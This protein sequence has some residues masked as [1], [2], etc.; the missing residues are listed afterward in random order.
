VK[1]FFKILLWLLVWTL[2]A[3]ACVGGALFA[4]YPLESGLNILGGLFVAYLAF[5]L[6]RKA[7]IHYQAKK[8]VEALVNT[9]EPDKKESTLRILRSK[10]GL[11]LNFRAVLKMLNRS[12]LKV[13]G[14]PVYVLP[15]YLVI[16]HD[17]SGKTFTLDQANLPKPTIDG[18]V[19]LRNDDG[20]NWHLYNQ[21]IVLDTPGEF[22]AG[23]A[24]SRN[25]EW[26]K[27]LALLKKHR[28]REPINGVIVTLPMDALLEGNSQKLI[29]MGTQARKNLEQLIQ[30]LHVQVPIYV[31]VT[32]LDLL[33]G[34]TEWI[35]NLDQERFRDPL[36]MVNT[37]EQSPG[38]FVG[39]TVRAL[40]ERLK[41]LQLTALQQDGVSADLIRLPTRFEGLERHLATYAE[42]IFQENPYQK[43][44][45][46]RGMYFMGE[47]RGVDLRTDSE[48]RGLFSN[49][50][51][52][53][54]VPGERGM[55]TSLARIER[56]ET[57]RRVGKV[58]V[59][60][61]VSAGV[62]AALYHNFQG[63]YSLLQQT[64]D[65]NAGNFEEAVAFEQN[66]KTMFGYRNM[67]EQLAGNG[68]APWFG[69]DASQPR[70]IGQLQEIF[71]E[72]VRTRLVSR[73]DQVFSAVMTNALYAEKGASEE[74][75]VAFISTLVRRINI[76][77]AYMAGADQDS[78]ARMPM[79]YSDSDAELFG[80]RDVATVEKL[81]SLYLQSLFWTA[82]QGQLQQELRLMDEQLRSILVQ[83]KALAN[84]L[85]PWANGVMAA[86]Q[87]RVGD[88][89]T[90]GSGELK[91][92]TAITGAYTL[93]GKQLIDGFIDQIRATNRYNNILDEILPGFAAS[94]KKQYLKQW[95]AFATNFQD[96]SSKL[97]NRDEWLTVINNLSTGRNIFFNA[98]DLIYEQLEPYIDDEDLPD[99]AMM[100]AYYQDMRAFGPE[101]KTDDG[102]QGQ[103]L[104]KMAMQVVGKAGPV[105][106]AIAGAGKSG[107]KSKKK[108]DKAAGKSGPSA[109]EREMQLEQAGTLLGDY[110][111]ALT[112]F[113]YSAEVR[114]VSYSAMAGLYANPDRPDQGES[115]LARGYASL[116]KLQGLVGK[117]NR[118][119]KAFWN[120]YTGALTLMQQ[121][122]VAESA[123][124]VQQGWEN[125]FL[126][127]LQGVPE[128]K[129]PELA[130]GSSGLLWNVLQTDLAPFVREQ[131]GAGYVAR[132][133]LG[134]VYPLSSSFLTFAARSRDARQAKQDTYRVDIKGMPTSTNLDAKYQ[135]SQTRL[136][137]RCAD[138]TVELI[139]RNFP[140]T[141]NFSWSTSC[142]DVVLSIDIGRFSL[143]K[144]YEGP[145]GFPNFLKE[146]ARGMKRFTPSD[147]PANAEQL[148]ES[149][150]SFMEVEYRITGQNALMAS[151]DNRGL[152]IPDRIAA[153]WPVNEV[154]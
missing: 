7:V 99:W 83:S 103:V 38:V 56:V 46:F 141:R 89:W 22:L 19:S 73:A 95:E 50:F 113:V 34:V 5:L 124:E 45:L 61:L 128:Y 151:L 109:D 135:V 105:G 134:S 137:L 150:V 143:E 17:Q 100:L 142:S 16:G 120:L 59:W 65:Q 68:W 1:T 40:A 42:S 33:P 108:L 4:G 144:R 94:Y 132:R 30:V 154:Q 51:F 75:I 153:C 110:R 74:Q 107:M 18:D 52:T 23:V 36:G 138:Q 80:I 24:G 140:I 66:I 77:D 78:L 148:R 87:V 57:G 55:L 15:W 92:D 60:Y 35:A 121:F 53:G 131:L 112:D 43:T 130:F 81:N 147:F 114:S 44:P 64:A 58:A 21:A 104:T 54:I 31:I 63:N 11:D 72:R 26:L 122:M 48:G 133:A 85:I 88:F 27:L 139:N 6:I 93:A 32:K 25:A 127:N 101:E 82:G 67:V 102:K 71:A 13:H 152:V 37:D 41:Q 145:L 10:T 79:P 20:I 70:F 49:R 106:K 115:S 129:L 14:D 29:E 28:S 69:F 111:Q 98:M 119:N 76:L 3:A 125:K 126:A 118:D 146:F 86:E 117:E 136:E 2:I 149:G 91:K 9:A 90:A 123:C 116:K 96:G 12:Y 39:N 62:M 47:A 84:W 8:K 97:R